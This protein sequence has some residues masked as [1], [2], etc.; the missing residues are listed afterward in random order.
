V[1]AGE[2]AIKINDSGPG[3]FINWNR[4]ITAGV[5]LHSKDLPVKDMS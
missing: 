2:Y 4:V 5:F 3:L 1:Q